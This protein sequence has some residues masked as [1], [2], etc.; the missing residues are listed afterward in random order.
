MKKITSLAVMVFLISTFCTAYAGVTQYDYGDAVGYGVATHTTAE[1]Q[2]LGTGWSNETHQLD[3]DT[4]DD[5]VKYSLNGGTWTVWGD[6]TLNVKQGDTV[7]FEFTVTR[8]NYG[9]HPYD[10]LGVWLDINGNGS[11]ADPGENILFARMDKTEDWGS[12]SGQIPDGVR[13]D[14]HYESKVFLSDSITIG[15]SFAPDIWLRAR[16]SCSESIN[17]VQG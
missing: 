11:W 3:P 15:T 2:K 12:G 6:D 1:W 9:R 8:A 7:Q 14:Q 17:G 4:F 10:D 13:T 5:G 16:V